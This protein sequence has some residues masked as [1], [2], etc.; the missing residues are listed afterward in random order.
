MPYSLASA[1]ALQLAA[2][3]FSMTTITAASVQA[4]LPT[5]AGLTA[6][7]IAHSVLSKVS[8]EALPL[9]QAD[10]QQQLYL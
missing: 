8:A 6:T 2:Q 3:A 1:E 9:L 7:C 10:F 5:L 4:R